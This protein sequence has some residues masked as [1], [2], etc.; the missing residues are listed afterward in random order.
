LDDDTRS[1]NR[2][3]RDSSCRPKKHLPLHLVRYTT[4]TED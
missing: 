1:Q 4:R 3:T 2:T